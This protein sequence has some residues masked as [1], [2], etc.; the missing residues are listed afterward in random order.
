M[1]PWIDKKKIAHGIQVDVRRLGEMGDDLARYRSALRAIA[2]PSG[3][4]VEQAERIARDALAERP[5]VEDDACHIRAELD[6]TLTL[7]DQRIDE[8]TIVLPY[9]D[10]VSDPANAC[11]PCMDRTEHGGHH[12]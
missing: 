2:S 5:I 7:C 4:T 10:L 8:D 12:A 9:A 3:K 6:P 11:W 1:T